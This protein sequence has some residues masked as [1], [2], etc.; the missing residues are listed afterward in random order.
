MANS[1]L[2]ALNEAVGAAVI[3]ALRLAAIFSR[4]M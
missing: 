1:V 3:F 4:S 2:Q